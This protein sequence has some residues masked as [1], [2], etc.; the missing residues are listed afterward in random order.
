MCDLIRAWISRAGFPGC[1]LLLIR[2]KKGSTKRSLK[3]EKKKHGD[4]GYIFLP[5]EFR[6]LHMPLGSTGDR[7]RG[8]V[9]VI[10][11]HLKGI[12]FN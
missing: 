7:Y 10:K 12:P 11:G 5:L 8:C 9:F 1:R 4:Q 2:P 3:R 6:S